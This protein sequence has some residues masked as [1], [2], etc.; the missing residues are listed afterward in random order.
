MAKRYSYSMI[1][2]ELNNLGY[3]TKSG[4]L[5]KKTS[6][7][8]ILNNKKYIGIL[9]YGKMI[10][11]KDPFTKTVT[12]RQAN[13]EDMIIF[14]NAIEPIIDIDLWEQVQRIK[15]QRKHSTKAKVKY[16]L[17]G[18]LICGVCGSS[19]VGSSMK[20]HDRRD[21]F[22]ICSGKKN[23]NDCDNRNIVKDRLENIISDIVMQ[24][25]KNGNLYN[26]ISNIID[27]YNA[28]DNDLIDKTNKDIDKKINKLI[29]RLNKAKEAYLNDV[30][31]LNEYKEE[32][33]QTNKQIELLK[34][35][36]I[37]NNKINTNKKMLK[38]AFELLAEQIDNNTALEL[39]DYIN[40]KYDQITL[41]IGSKFLDKDIG[42][43]ADGI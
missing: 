6:I 40:I 3:R 35:Q 36:K 23:H 43:G 39:C 18:K 30:F 13:T 17:T 32:Q 37:L 11:T 7:H 24:E 10:T 2:E 41:T 9:E 34:S 5:F 14:E 8:E 29:V 27:S 38:L 20:T 1:I 33:Y 12:T 31:S 22:Y 15:G 26:E 4:N 42:G 16:N 19:Y 25:L 21:Y 28:K